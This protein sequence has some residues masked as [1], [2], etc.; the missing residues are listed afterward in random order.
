VRLVLSH[1]AGRTFDE[2]RVVDANSPPIGRAD[3][4]ILDD[5]SVVVLWL[6][7]ASGSGAELRVRRY[8]A[9][10]R[11][12]APLTVTELKATRSAGFPRLAS[13]GD[14]ALVA[15]TD[16]GPRVGLALLVLSPR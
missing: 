8:S 1:D 15:W 13:F 6:A 5:D 9:T 2:P 11:P 16:T 14:R 12:D 3:V 7:R 4:T 10:G